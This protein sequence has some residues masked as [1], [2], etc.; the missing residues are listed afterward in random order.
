[1]CFLLARLPGNAQNWRSSSLLAPHDPNWERPRLGPANCPYLTCWP[2]EELEFRDDP[3]S[4]LVLSCWR[5][6][7]GD[8]DDDGSVDGL[9][10]SFEDH[11]PQ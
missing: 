4:C 7:D 6:R 9:F 2:I 3:P 5:L 11:G 8:R 1:M 10:L